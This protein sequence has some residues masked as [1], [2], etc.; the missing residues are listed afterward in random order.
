MGRAVLV[1]GLEEA[2]LKTDFSAPD[3]GWFGCC[4]LRCGRIDHHQ[5]M[6]GVLHVFQEAGVLRGRCQDP[7]CGPGKAPMRGRRTCRGRSAAQTPWPRVGVVPLGV[8]S[9][10]CPASPN[11]QSPPLEHPPARHGHPS[12][13]C[14]VS[15]GA[16]RG[17][18]A[19][20]GSSETCPTDLNTSWL[21]PPP[22]ARTGVLGGWP[23]TSGEACQMEQ[24]QTGTCH[25]LS[26]EL[27]TNA[28]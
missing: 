17:A 10:T 21:C 14:R 23:G 15:R 3:T 19:G 25:P 24:I 2:S 13:T 9:P 20:A 5:P 8:S 4:P 16:R 1:G 27:Q 7:P 6:D 22:W 28:K 18:G 11:R 26:F 12:S